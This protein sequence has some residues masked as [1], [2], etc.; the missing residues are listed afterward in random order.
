V[1]LLDESP[2]QVTAG[3]M[4]LQRFAIFIF[5]KILCDQLMGL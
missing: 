4:K 2:A 3:F 1:R 5:L